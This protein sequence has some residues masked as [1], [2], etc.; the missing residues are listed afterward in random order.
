MSP[1]NFQITY[2]STRGLL[3]KTTDFHY[4]ISN[5]DYDI[6]ALTP[7]FL[8]GS[9]TSSELFT[10]EYQIFRRDCDAKSPSESDGSG[11]LIAVN[12]KFVIYNR[13]NKLLDFVLANENCFEPVEHFD[14]SFM[15]ENSQHHT[16]L[17]ITS[18]HNK[19][20][21]LGRSAPT[22]RNFTR[23]NYDEING[24]LEAHRLG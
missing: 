10:S 18:A 6:L 12:S 8:N 21:P 5:N 1:I 4:Y 20:K 14:D 9:V 2:Q 24:K 3:Y 15:T 22:V 23:A 17:R 11:V 7:T 13:N 16:V 19:W